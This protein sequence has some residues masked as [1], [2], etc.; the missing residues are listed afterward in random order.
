[1]SEDADSTPPGPVCLALMEAVLESGAETPGPDDRMDSL[2]IDSLDVLDLSFR[3][4]R[5]FKAPAA[6]FDVVFTDTPKTAA[7]REFAAA[8][9]VRLREAGYVW[10]DSRPW[11][12]YTR[13][14]E[15]IRLAE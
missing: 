12:V 13:N 3:M 9:E 14:G 15:E 1:M 6:F 4:E 11:C 8:A 10:D 7:V 2:G 5:K